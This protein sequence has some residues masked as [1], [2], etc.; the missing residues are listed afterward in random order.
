MDEEK[1][2]IRIVGLI[3]GGTS[4]F[5]GQYVV[6]YDPGRDGVEPMGRPMLCHLVTTSD[7]RSAV[8][9]GHATAKRRENEKGDG[10]SSSAAALGLALGLQAARAGRPSR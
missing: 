7:V 3:N 6:E 10:A 2:V 8:R 5:D 4:A 1:R 9:D